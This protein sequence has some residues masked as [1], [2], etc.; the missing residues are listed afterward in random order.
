MKVQNLE[1]VLQQIDVYQQQMQS[2][3]HKI[4]EEEQQLR[5]VMAPTYL[6]HD[7]EKAMAEQQVSGFFDLFKLSR[8]YNFIYFS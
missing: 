2:L 5:A 1:S 3:R 4:I 6:P 8:R 7:R